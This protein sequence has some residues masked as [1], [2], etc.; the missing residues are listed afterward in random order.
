MEHSCPLVVRENVILDYN[1]STAVQENA[2][3]GRSYSSTGQEKAPFQHSYALVVQ[4][5][6][7]SQCRGSRVVP[8][9]KLLCDADACQG[10][11][12]R[13]WSSPGPDFGH[14]EATPS[15]YAGFLALLV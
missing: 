7:P 10:G 2:P 13:D 11:S 15:C 4:E 8:A 6:A 1:C 5:M 3:S 9:M 12:R 14:F